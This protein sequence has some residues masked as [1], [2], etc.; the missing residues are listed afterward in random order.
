MLVAT[1]IF[2]LEQIFVATC[3][4]KSFV[5]RKVLLRQ[6]YFVATKLLSCQAY[7]CRD[8]RRVLYFWWELPHVLFLSRVCSFVATK[9]ILVRAP[10]NFTA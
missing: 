8:K 2:L 9:I 3:C 10:T 7:F 4:D 5:A 1:N 6:K